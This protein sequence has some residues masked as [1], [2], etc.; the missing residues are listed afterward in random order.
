MPW[1]RG[2]YKIL[3]CIPKSLHPA[4]HS[5][6][7]SSCPPG[8]TVAQGPSDPCPPQPRD[9]PRRA[10]AALGPGEQCPY[11]SPYPPQ[12]PGAEAPTRNP[13]PALLPKLSHGSQHP[14]E[15]PREPGG[16]LWGPQWQ[17]GRVT[18]PHPRAPSTPG[19][20]TG[21]TTAS[22]SS[23]RLF[24]KQ[25]CSRSDGLGGSR[26]PPGDHRGYLRTLRPPLP[27]D[28]WGARTH[29]SPSGPPAAQAPRG[30]QGGPGW[31]PEGL[32]TGWD[33]PRAAP[34]GHRLLPGALQGGWIHGAR[35]SPP[36]G[37]GS[38]PR[39]G[40]S[41]LTSTSQTPTPPT[42]FW[43]PAARTV[44]S[45]E[46]SIQGVPGKCLPGAG[47]GFSREASSPWSHS[48]QVAAEGDLPGFGKRRVS[49]W[50]RREW[51][52]RRGRKR[53]RPSRAAH[54]EGTC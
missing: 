16:T 11:S 32:G 23:A 2:G 36:R 40:G 21:S 12:H 38:P 47:T 27:P 41:H 33:E 19:A 14:P 45:S 35:E 20:S 8:E 43:G 7:H 44:E 53:E 24:P 30:G 22:G 25:G 42:A 9:L 29:L 15:H 6:R 51:F 13:S 26:G 31:A 37:S 49:S 28:P 52:P 10:Q 50:K 1:E 3:S 54:P 39:G 46:S 48:P 18:A 17:W 34:G 4:L 5:D